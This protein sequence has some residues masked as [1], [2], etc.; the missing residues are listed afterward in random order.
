LLAQTGPATYAGLRF[1]VAGNIWEISPSVSNVG[2]PLINYAPIS[3]ISYPPGGGNSQIQF[4]N[5]SIFDG[6]SSLTFNRTTNTLTLSGSQVLKNV[7]NT[8]PTAI[9]NATTIYSNPTQGGGTGLYV[10]TIDAN[11]E[12]I[13]KSRAII[14]S[15][16]F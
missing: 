3:T 13:S 10:K 12:L 8:I 9:A 15:I 5:N 1:N 14:Y 11:D 7:G 16:I 4:N 6:S 2:S